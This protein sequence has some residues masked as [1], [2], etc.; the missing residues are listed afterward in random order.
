MGSRSQ[1]YPTND[2]AGTSPEK[3]GEGSSPSREAK[4]SPVVFIGLWSL[5]PALNP[6][7]WEEIL[8]GGTGR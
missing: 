5:R 1:L 6:E 3:R 4:L 2:I 7:E 8:T